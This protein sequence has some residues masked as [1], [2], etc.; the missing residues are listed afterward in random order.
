MSIAWISSIFLLELP[1]TD[2]T[3]PF[4]FG[5]SKMA[6]FSNDC[7]V[8]PI[9]RVYPGV[10]ARNQCKICRAL[11]NVPVRVPKPQATSFIMEIKVIRSI[12]FVGT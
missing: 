5:T 3:I 6:I 12:A 8:L 10:Q 4:G 9:C 2:K 7:I 1:G 11:G